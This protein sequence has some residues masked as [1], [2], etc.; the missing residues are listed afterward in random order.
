MIEIYLAAAVALV[1]TGLTLGIVLIISIGIHVEERAFR[2][3][4]ACT[5]KRLRLGV[6]RLITGR[7][8]PRPD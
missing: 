1:A 5:R 3:R 7:Q 4:L 8:G 6:R 2:Q